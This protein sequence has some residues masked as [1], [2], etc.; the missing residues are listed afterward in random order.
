MNWLNIENREVYGKKWEGME[1][2]SK[3][4]IQREHIFDYFQNISAK[5]ILHLYNI[6]SLGKEKL[7]DHSFYYFFFKHIF[8][9]SFL[10]QFLA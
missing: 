9:F 6:S 10:F 1:W 4:T 7:D 5:N 3:K 2:E 8:L